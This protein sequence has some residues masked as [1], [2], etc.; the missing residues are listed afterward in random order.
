MKV[1]NSGQKLYSIF[2]DYEKCYDKINRLFLWQKLLSENVSSKM[3]NAIKAIFG[4]FY[5]KA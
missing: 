3:T 1:L 5:Y 4:T 2:I